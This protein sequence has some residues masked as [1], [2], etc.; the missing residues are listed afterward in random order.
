[1]TGRGANDRCTRPAAAMPLVRALLILGV[2][3]ACRPVAGRADDRVTLQR[4]GSAGAITVVGEIEDFT[5]RRLTIRVKGAGSLQSFPADEV[6]TVSTSHSPAHQQGLQAFEAGA[7][8]V[9]EQ[10]FARAL[11]VEG[12]SWVQQDLLAGMVRSAM[13]RGDRISAAN[14]FVRMVEQEPATR[15]WGVIPLMW[16]PESIGRE[17]RSEAER[18]LAARPEAARLLGA[19]ILLVDAAHSPAARRALDDL[20][21]SPEPCV[22]SLARAQLWRLR[23]AAGDFTSNQMQSWRGQIETMPRAARAGPMYTLGRAAALRSDLEQ[24]AADWLWLPLV[25]DE[26]EP[27][28]ARACVEAAHALLR[29]GRADEAA[30]LYREA[31]ERFGWSPFAEEARQRLKELTDEGAARAG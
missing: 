16:A 2:L 18:L 12:R 5:S 1:M 23:L 6:L 21:R 26:D 13:R 30:T 10:E 8:A 31:A 9:A 19:S 22:S 28:A 25:Y 4:A 3:A 14:S 15:H 7:Y 27:L 17:L 29:L 20:A 24:A 11:A